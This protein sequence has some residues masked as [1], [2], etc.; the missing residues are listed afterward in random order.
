MALHPFDLTNNTG[1]PLVPPHSIHQFD[2]WI[3]TPHTLVL[4]KQK[5]T[6]LKT[7]WVKHTL[8]LTKVCPLPQQHSDFEFNKTYVT[9][10]ANWFQWNGTPW[11]VLVDWRIDWNTGFWHGGCVCLHK[12]AIESTSTK[13]EWCQ[14]PV[15]LVLPRVVPLMHLNRLL[16]GPEPT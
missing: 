4:F 10:T 15:M 1:F 5:L 2:F 13:S 9:V 6:W 3:L 14:C 11:K 16:S 8:P 12:T 7:W